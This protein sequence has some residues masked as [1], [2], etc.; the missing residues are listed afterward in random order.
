MLG[1]KP[2]SGDRELPTF[3]R[4]PIAERRSQEFAEGD[5]AS[6][7]RSVYGFNHQRGQKIS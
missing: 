4:L 5:I 1:L 7:K 6:R 2:F 3:D